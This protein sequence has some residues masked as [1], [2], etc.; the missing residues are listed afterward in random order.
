L[1]LDHESGC[2]DVF[3]GTWRR[4][5]GYEAAIKLYL[6]QDALLQKP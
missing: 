2:R 6:W 4:I 3:E 5:T 1:A